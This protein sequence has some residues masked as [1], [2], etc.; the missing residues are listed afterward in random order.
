M[1]QQRQCQSHN[2]CVYMKKKIVVNG[3]NTNGIHF[4]ELT[5]HFQN[6]T[7][8]SF[9]FSVVILFALAAGRATQGTMPKILFHTRV[10]RFTYAT[11]FP[12]TRCQEH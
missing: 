6:S 5:D 11:L 7:V 1:L 9:V 3:M 8:V 2:A 12:S 4:A 10:H